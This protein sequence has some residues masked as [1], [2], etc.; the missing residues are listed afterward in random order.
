MDQGHYMVCP[1]WEKLRE[2]LDMTKILD[3]VKFFQQMLIQMER[4]DDKTTRDPLD[5]LSTTSD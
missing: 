2:G 3:M 5:P 1:A 4:K